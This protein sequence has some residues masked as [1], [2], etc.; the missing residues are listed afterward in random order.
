M[1]TVYKITNTKNSKCYIGITSRTVDERW[2]EHLSRHR[3]NL[4]NN[5]LYAAIRKYGTDS[6]IIESLH[7]SDSED[8]IRKLEDLYIRK[9]DSYENGYNCNYG[10]HGFL[11]IPDDIKIKIG[12]S[13]KGKIISMEARK[14]MSSAKQGDSRCAIHFGNYT[15]K[16]SDNPK[17]FWFLIGLPTG[18]KQIIRGLREFCRDN[19]ISQCLMSHRGKTKGFFLL[20]RFTDHPEREYVQADGSGAHPIKGEDMVGSAWQY[21]AVPMKERVLFSE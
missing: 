6:F 11:H 1:N 20:K 8:E 10:G 19:H 9:F 13:Q 18:T 15:N 16:G 2:Q 17:A 21:A 14:K 7:S 5:R 12:E 4:R 3:C